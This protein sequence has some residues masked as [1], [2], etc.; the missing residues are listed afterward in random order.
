LG[1]HTGGAAI[2]EGCA[3]SHERIGAAP[4]PTTITLD[5][6]VRR[7]LRYFRN[8]FGA[9]ERSYEDYKGVLRRLTRHFEDS[10]LAS[11]E[12]PEGTERLRAFIDELWGEK[13]SGTRGKVISVYKSFFKW[14][15]EADLLVGDPGAKL[16]RPK[17]R[18]VERHAHEPSVVKKIILA[19]PMLRDRVAIMLMARLGLRKNELRTLRYGDIEI[20]GEHKSIRVRG[21][22]GK[23]ARIPIVYPDML[24]Q[25][26]AL[27]RLE[28]PADTDY[29]L[30]PIRVGN[31]KRAQHLSGVVRVDRHKPLEPSSMH[32]WFAKCLERAGVDHFPMHE[33]RHSAATEFLR[34]TGDLEL[35][36][37]FCRHESVAT[38][39]IYAHLLV[40]DLVA[41][42]AK[43]EARWS[44]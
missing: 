7:Y 31:V 3:L 41:G 14:T 44:A 39:Q 9:T 2:S 24:E 37:M 13:S 40:D 10:P 21:K 34:A 11:W 8:E 23:V 36:R 38:T 26:Q 5:E 15:F 33:L 35:T 4:T 27:I 16:K 43:A 6:A 25:L 28:E 30:Y 29:L 17:R 18:G 19:Q 42:M 22:G 20:A 1:D 32:R 12:P